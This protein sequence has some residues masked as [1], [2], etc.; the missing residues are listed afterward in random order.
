MKRHEVMSRLIGARAEF[1]MKLAAIPRERLEHACPGTAH[2]PKEIVAHVVAYEELITERLRSARRGEVTEFDRDRVG[3][4][5]FNDRV[6][7]EARDTNVDEVLVRSARSFADVLG[8]VALL[9]DAE[10][11]ERV[12]VVCSIDPAWLRDR[13]LAEMIAIDGFE[14]Y[15]MHLA[16]L[17]SAANA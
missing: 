10:L 5:A 4:E 12:G 15:P 11:N 17:E 8:E 13:S 3:W 9:E 7:S 6:W 2:T 14:H 1:D 16:A